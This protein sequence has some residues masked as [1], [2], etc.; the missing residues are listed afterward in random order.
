MRQCDAAAGASGAVRCA[1]R[2]RDLWAALLSQPFPHLHELA[3]ADRDHFVLLDVYL[4]DCLEEWCASGG[5]LSAH[6]CAA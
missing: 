3:S 4:R 6:H 1:M 5:Q 2:T